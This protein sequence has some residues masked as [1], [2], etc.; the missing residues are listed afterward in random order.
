M[1]L[2]D[3]DTLLVTGYLGI[4]LL[5]ETFTWKRAPAPLGALRADNR[6]YSDRLLRPWRAP[7]RI[8]P[9][10]RSD[11]LRAISALAGTPACSQLTKLVGAVGHDV[12][13]LVER[14]HVV[15]VVEHQRVDQAAEVRLQIV[16]IARLAMSSSRGCTISAGWRTLPRSGFTPPPAR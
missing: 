4:K 9:P 10:A 2:D 8:R 3:A 15:A 12:A 1:Q 14:D 5:G 13:L 11:D 16:R 6:R 7:V